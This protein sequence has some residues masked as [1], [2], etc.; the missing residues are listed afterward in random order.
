M[1]HRTSHNSIPEY[2]I[3]EYSI[4]LYSIVQCYMLLPWQHSY[5]VVF[6]L[7]QCE[8][9]LGFWRYGLPATPKP[10]P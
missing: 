5:H 7:E 9:P 4:V 2:S 6:S 3:V 1:H 8:L 10:L